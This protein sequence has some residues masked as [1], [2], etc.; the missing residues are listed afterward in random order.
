MGIR[1]PWEDPE[2]AGRVI[3]VML[4]VIGISDPVIPLFMHRNAGAVP[5]LR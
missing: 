2:K 1:G 5:L 3:L 4:R